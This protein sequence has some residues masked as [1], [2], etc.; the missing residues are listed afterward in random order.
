MKSFF[1]RTGRGILKFAVFAVLFLT[2]YHAVTVSLCA[3]T[4]RS[5]ALFMYKTEEKNTIDVLFLGSSHSYHAFLPMALWRDYGISSYNLATSQQPISGAYYALE[6]ALKTQKPKVVVLEL[7]GAYYNAYFKKLKMLHACTDFIPFGKLKLEMWR[8]LLRDNMS[9]TE[10]LE[11]LFPIT[12]YHTRWE[13]LEKND[14]SLG[15]SFYKGGNPGYTFKAVKK[16]APDLEIEE[17]SYQITDYLDR[18]AQCCRKNGAELLF[19]FTPIADFKGYK[20]ITERVNSAISYGEK[21]GIPT[22]RFTD[23]QDEIGLNYETDFY[24]ETHLNMLGAEK[25]TGY[26]GQYLRDN[27][28]LSDHREEAAYEKWNQDLKSYKNEVTPRIK[29]M[30]ARAGI[31]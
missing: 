10:Q 1:G 16:A 29:K 28:N 4:N 3:K 5:K 27:Y 22:I 12:L 17:V 31:K 13:E 2:V 19:C 14:F 20:V 7:Y 15:R 18:I 6:Q 30:K 25:C 9:F 21:L 24:D 11:F 26:I 8:D 23:V